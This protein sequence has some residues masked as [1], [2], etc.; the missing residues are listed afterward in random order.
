MIRVNVASC[1]QLMHLSNEV[2]GLCMFPLNIIKAVITVCAG[3]HL[4]GTVKDNN[5]DSSLYPEQDRRFRVS[6]NFDRY[7]GLHT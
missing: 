4:S 1:V 6:V 5:A 7:V 3:F 2:V